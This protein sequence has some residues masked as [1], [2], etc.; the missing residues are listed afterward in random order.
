MR[1]LLGDP[2]HLEPAVCGVDGS[3]DVE[4]PVLDGGKHSKKSHNTRLDCSLPVGEHFSSHRHS[5]SDLRVSVL[6]DGLHDTQ[7]CRVAEQ[8]LIAKFRTHEDGLNRD[9]G[10]M[11]HYL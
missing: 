2:L 7:Q 11:S 10:F 1:D 6:Q 8:K 3:H 5:A 4:M 9:H